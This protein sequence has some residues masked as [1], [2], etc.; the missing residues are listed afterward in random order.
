MQYKSTP[1]CYKNKIQLL[2]Y[3][4]EF[5]YYINQS[6]WKTCLLA[7]IIFSYI[8]TIIWL[9]L[10]WPIFDRCFE[11]IRD[12]HCGFYSKYQRIKVVLFVL[13]VLLNFATNCFAWKTVKRWK[14]TSSFHD[15]Q[16][17]WFTLTVTFHCLYKKSNLI[18]ITIWGL[19]YIA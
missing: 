19:I 11:Q 15:S 16:S 3:T 6:D 1:D 13:E 18:F 12:K 14:I 4:M 8:Y 2:I 17:D 5:K 9:K 10:I 7:I